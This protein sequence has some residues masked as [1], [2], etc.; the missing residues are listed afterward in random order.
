MSES[1]QINYDCNKC[2]Y[3]TTNKFSYN[4]HIASKKHI[5]MDIKIAEME[6]KEAEILKKM[7]EDKKTRNNLIKNNN[8]E[9]DED[10]SE[11]N[12]GEEEDC[13]EENC[14]DEDCSEE[15]CEEENEEEKKKCMEEEEE[16]ATRDKIAKFI[17]LYMKMLVKTLNKIDENYKFIKNPKILDIDYFLKNMFDEQFIVMVYDNINEFINTK[18]PNKINGNNINIDNNFNI[19]MDKDFEGDIGDLINKIVMGVKMGVKK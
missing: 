18:M 4:T 5:N 17:S 8:C 19:F 15:D 9:E 13:S 16:D 10:C 14:G 7:E 2:G 3:H 1:K 12:C 6:K 11:E